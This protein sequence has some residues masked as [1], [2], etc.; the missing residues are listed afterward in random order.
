M[1]KITLFIF[2]IFLSNFVISQN[3]EIIKSVKT[4]DAV[5]AIKV[6]TVKPWYLDGI[7]SLNF[8]QA[9]FSNWSSG[10]QNSLGLVSYLNLKA[11]YKKGKH[12]W[13]NT[14]ELGYGFIIQGKMDDAKYTKSN[15]QIE[16][17]SAYGYSI[18][19]DNKWMVT[20]LVNLRTQFSN[21]Y[22]Y[23]N[24]STI[25]SKFMSPGY[26]VTGIGITYAPAKWFYM[27]LS[28]VSGRFT[29]VLDKALSDSGAFGVTRG[30]HML[31]ELGPY[32]RADMNKDLSKTINLATTVEFFTN[33]FK[34]FGNIDVNW[35]L[36]LTMKVNKWLAASLATQLIYDDNVK[37]KTS[38]TDQ[39]IPHTQF[40]ELFGLGLTYRIR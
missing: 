28:P 4:K 20:V 16:L 7:A 37:I 15:D 39:A 6:D 35:G 22:N 12:S 10:G 33:Y 29:F 25:T 23:P 34:D 14:L 19:K 18:S 32:L 17:T 38:P 36:L 9:S 31:A 1:K 11:N 30:K 24:D 26:L 27:Y 2:L 40:K 3:N 21:G 5:A 13:G 8:S